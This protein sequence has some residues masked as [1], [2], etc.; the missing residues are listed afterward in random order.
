MIFK[1]AAVNWP[2]KL[3]YFYHKNFMSLL[4]QIIETATIHVIKEQAIKFFLKTL[5][6]RN[7]SMTLKYLLDTNQFFNYQ[8]FLIRLHQTANPNT[9]PGY[10]LVTQTLLMDVLAKL[11]FENRNLQLSLLSQNYFYRSFE[12]LLKCDDDFQFSLCQR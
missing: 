11:S 1:H 10:Y 3:L 7:S 8:S 5:F 2:E 4:Q 6:M 9:Q 12:Y